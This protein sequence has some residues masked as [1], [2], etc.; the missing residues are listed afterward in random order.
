MCLENSTLFI[1]YTCSVWQL[2]SAISSCKPLFLCGISHSLKALNIQNRQQ[3]G[4]WVVCVY[5]SHLIKYM[6]Q[7][8]QSC[9]VLAVLYTQN[10]LAGL[11]ECFFLAYVHTHAACDM[12]CV[13]R[14]NKKIFTH[15]QPKCVTN[16]TEPVFKFEINLNNEK[17]YWLPAQI[18]TPCLISIQ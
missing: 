2:T 5:I 11:A 3:G 4:K 18:H 8:F 7:A 6:Y 13:T 14:D 9:S 1:L 15:M 16:G 10:T 12:Q 17:D